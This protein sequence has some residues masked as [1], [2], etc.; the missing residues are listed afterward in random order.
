VQQVRTREFSLDGHP[1][2]VHLCGKF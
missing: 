2:G 1:I